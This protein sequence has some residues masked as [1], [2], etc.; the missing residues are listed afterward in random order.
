M[1]SFKQRQQ[2]QLARLAVD[3]R[4]QDHA[5]R[6]LHLRELEEVVQNNLRFFA[7]L[8]LD[9][10]AHAFAVGFV[11]HVGDA[12]DFLGL[13]EF[14]DALDQARLVHLVGNFGDDDALAVLARMA[15][16]AALARM[17]KLPRPVL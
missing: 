11:A 10:D 15:S 1:N 6:F 17:M 3:D 12:F 7:A 4:E 2:A 9:H 8:Y 5:E 14:R 16:M 13:H